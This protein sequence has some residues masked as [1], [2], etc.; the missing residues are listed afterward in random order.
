M[1]R[2]SALLFFVC[3]C[4]AGIA[5]A[6]APTSANVFV[7]YSFEHAG[8]SALNAP[9]ASNRPNLQG[10]Q[11]SVEGKVFGPIGIV[12]DFSGHYGSQSYFFAVPAGPG[13]PFTPTVTGH[14]LEVLFGPRFS[15]PIRRLRLFVQSEFGLA[16]MNTDV[17][18][19]DTS[20]AVAAGGGVDYRIIRPIAWRAEVDGVFTKLFDAS[21]AN[22]R[23]ST[24]IVFR[25]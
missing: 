8:A 4:F 11:A 19:S 20:F 21:Q 7:G 2:F 5:T 25:F 23:I 1:R 3:L 18:G 10:W 24:G 15:L 13:T 12:A 9:L 14:E 6:Q 17:F 16:H 22:L